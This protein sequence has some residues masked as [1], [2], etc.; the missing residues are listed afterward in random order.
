MRAPER[1]RIRRG[2]RRGG[3]AAANSSNGDHVVLDVADS[4]GDCAASRSRGSPDPPTFC[5]LEV[6]VDHGVYVPRWQSEP[7][8]RRAAARLPP[9]GIAID[10][11]TGSGAIAMTLRVARPERTRRRH[12]PRRAGR[13]V[14]DDPTASRSI[15][16][17]SSRRS[18]TD[19]TARSTSIVGVVPYVPDA[20]AC[21]CCRATRWT[22][23][24]PLSY[25]G[26]DDGVDILRRVVREESPVPSTRRRGAPRDRWRSR[27][28]APS[29]PHR[30]RLR[31]RHV[32]LR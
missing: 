28:S 24:R 3:R 27:R 19:S 23:S 25:D 4:N 9:S 2:R 22:S 32:R 6:R 10:V 15:A 12:R 30:T 20:R 29:R 8:A 1:R 18:P 13:R 5:G 7:L 31:R 11:C 21:R 17:T 26:G 14:R 16:A